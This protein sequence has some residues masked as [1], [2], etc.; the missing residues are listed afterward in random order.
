LLRLPQVIVQ[1]G[2]G[3]STLY[4]AI[5]A[6]TFPKPVPLT[7]TA[8]AWRSDEVDAWIAARI[9]ARDEGRPA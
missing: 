7:T 9:A 6:G 3:R 8:R 4:D 5:R 1:T 2:C